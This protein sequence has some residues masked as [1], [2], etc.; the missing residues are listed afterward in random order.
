LYIFAVKSIYNFKSICKTA[1]QAFDSIDQLKSIVNSLK[2]SNNNI[3][4]EDNQLIENIFNICQD[5]KKRSD[6]INKKQNIYL[7]RKKLNKRRKYK[8]SSNEN[9]YKNELK[10]LLNNEQLFGGTK[11]VIDK[12]IAVNFV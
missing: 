1:I 7:I 2:E 8:S 10:I 3:T 4:I 6:L 11:E 12:N 9:F 5:Y